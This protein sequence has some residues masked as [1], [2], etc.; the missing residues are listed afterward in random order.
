MTIHYCPFCPL[1]YWWKS[2]LEDHLHAEHNGFHHDYPE[3]RLRHHDGGSRVAHS[4]Y[5]PP[6]L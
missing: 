5:S 6:R 1:R 4:D 3:A 2:E